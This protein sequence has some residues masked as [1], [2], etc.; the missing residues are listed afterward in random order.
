MF[1][2]YNKDIYQDD[3]KDSIFWQKH[4]NSTYTQKFSHIQSERDINNDEFSVH[5]YMLLIL[6]LL[7]FIISIIN[8]Q[9]I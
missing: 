2:Y 8:Y 5:K 1:Q 4:R 7:L 6:L 9:I 3:V